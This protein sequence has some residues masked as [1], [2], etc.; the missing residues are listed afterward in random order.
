MKK[1]QPVSA[2]RSQTMLMSSHLEYLFQMRFCS[3]GVFFI[4]IL[5][6]TKRRRK[7]P[8]LAPVLCRGDGEDRHKMCC[9][10]WEVQAGLEG[11]TG[12]DCSAHGFPVDPL[13][14]VG[15]ARTGWMPKW[16][17]QRNVSV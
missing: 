16:Q 4:K 3:L 1:S 9:T 8:W 14:R 11:R 10:C 7:T 13:C 17:L 12:G 6:K 5:K 15:L 2:G